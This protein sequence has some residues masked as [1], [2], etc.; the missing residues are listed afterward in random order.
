VILAIRLGVPQLDRKGQK[1]TNDESGL[2]EF[3]D[4]LRHVVKPVDVLNASLAS[5]SRA[6]QEV[7]HDF[8][9]TFGAA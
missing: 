4:S 6:R 3:C 7:G 9:R 1:Q 5:A 8:S 2:I